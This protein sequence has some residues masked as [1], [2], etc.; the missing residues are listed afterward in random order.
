MEKRH[1]PKEQIYHSDKILGQL[2]DKVESVNFIPHYTQPFDRRIRDAR[3]PTADTLEI[4]RQLKAKYDTAMRRIMA[5]QEIETEFEVWSTFS[6]SKPRVGTDYKMQEELANI[7]G[8][9]KD[10]FRRICIEA[11]GGKDPEH[12]E[13]FV[14]AMYQVTWEEMEIALAECRKTKIV[15]GNTVPIRK[16]EPKNMPL[17]SFPWLFYEVLGKLAS[18]VSQREGLED[19]GLSFLSTVAHPERLRKMKLVDVSS[20]DA[21][22]ETERGI[23]HLGEEFDLE[24][25]PEHHTPT[26]S[27]MDDLALIDISESPLG[28]VN[29]ATTSISPPLPAGMEDL[30][31]IT[32]QTENETRSRIEKAPTSVTLLFS[33]SQQSAAIRSGEDS[34]LEELIE[35]GTI[36]RAEDSPLKRLMKLTERHHKNDQLVEEKESVAG[37]EQESPLEKLTKLT[38]KEGADEGEVEIEEIVAVTAEGDSPLKRLSELTEAAEKEDKEVEGFLKVHQ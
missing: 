19:S 26:A 9:L 17:I 4:S 28:W 7:A 31:T 38:G 33:N 35:E 1:K 11:A 16:M 12:L 27:S 5:Q 34:N 8:A 6:L 10:R 24:R 21:G 13:S 22:V 29:G 36:H 2:Y 3:T 20:F 14:A 37:P 32:N 15:G 23:I 25:L 30:T 18:G